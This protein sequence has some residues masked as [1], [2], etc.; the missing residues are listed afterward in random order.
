[1]LE[2]CIPADAISFGISTDIEVAEHVDTAQG[3]VEAAERLGAD[4]IC[5]GTHGRT[6]LASAILGSTAMALLRLS[7]K[8]VYLVRPLAD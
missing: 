6:G 4:A 8:P 3:I 5:I 2:A 1:M 7:D